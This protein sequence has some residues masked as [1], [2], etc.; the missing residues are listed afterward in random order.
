MSR[1]NHAVTVARDVGMRMRD[2]VEL[3]CDVYTPEGPGPYPVILMRSPYDKATS[4]FY[5][6]LH[7]EWYAR[8]GF[9]VVSQDTRGCFASGGDFVP[10]VHETR[11]GVDTIAQVARLPKSS[12]K[13]GMYG[14]SY[15]GLVQLLAAAERPAGLAAIAPAF[16]CDGA[17]EDWTYKNGALA[18]A[19][20]QSWAASFVVAEAFRK[21][22]PADV[23]PAIKALNGIM[24]EY[25]HLPLDDHP[26]LPRRFAPFYYDWLAHPTF[27]AFW[28]PLHLGDRY[29]AIDVPALH[30]GGWYDL[31]VEGTIRN[32]QGLATGAGSEAARRGQKLVIG[33][34]YHQPW[35]RVTADVDFGEAGAN[36]T[37][38]LLVRW[39]GHWL[40][41][42]A[43]GVMDEPPV[44][45]FV[46]G[47]NAWRHDATFPPAGMRPTRF[48]LRSDGR[49]NALDGTGSLAE[50]PPGEEPC[51]I[52]VTDPFFPVPSLGGRSCCPAELAPMGPRD[53][54]AIEARPDVLVYTTPPLERP[55]ELVGPVDAVLHASSTA[56]DTDFVVKLVDVFPD[57]RAVNLVSGIQRASFRESN[58]APAPIE[59]GRVYRYAFRVG[60]TA[61]RFLAGHRIRVEI[62]GTS[63][64]QWERT[65]N[66]FRLD[67]GGGY[68]DARP[69]TQKVFHDP[70][71]PS[72]V[73]LPVVP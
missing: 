57:G 37:D 72:A 2:G 17:Y 42:E 23:R 53:Q 40:K 1:A 43:N 35:S 15:P 3:K 11:D 61:N 44:S 10:F 31:F 39:Y 51:D 36:R 33:P 52:F 73:V 34:W 29:G 58:A 62:A 27:D 38:D 71:R 22:T 12:G 24:A 5:S 55:L 9:I 69:A 32:F 46:M 26:A 54:R 45:L 6:L 18:L 67:R 21:G 59:P 4:E 7:P 30:L 13:V 41:G 70:A 56:D 20:I 50:T 47:A 28:K 16:T 68:A 19:F 14:F 48:H 60:H 49:A 63:F 66:R 64:P 65:R 25:D 8:H